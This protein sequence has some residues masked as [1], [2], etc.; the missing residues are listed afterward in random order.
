[1]LIDVLVWSY[2]ALLLYVASRQR[3]PLRHA[4]EE[5]V[6]FLFGDL[7]GTDKH[8]SHHSAFYLLDGS[9]NQRATTVHALQLYSTRGVCVVCHDDCTMECTKNPDTV[10]A[11]RCTVLFCDSD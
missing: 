10:V 1:M 7:E 8:L 9:V 3:R 2:D 11:S 6:R 4:F 5:C